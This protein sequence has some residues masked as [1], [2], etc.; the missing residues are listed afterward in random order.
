MKKMT[1][2]LELQCKKDNSK[3]SRVKSQNGRRLFATHTQQQQQQR[4]SALKYEKS[5]LIQ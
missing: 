4:N 5:S 3:E 2:K 1:R